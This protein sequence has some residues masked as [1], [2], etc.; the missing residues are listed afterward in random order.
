[1][2]LTVLASSSAG[3]GYLLTNG[4]ETLIIEAGIRLKSVKGALNFS[5]TGIAGCLVSHRHGD[6]SKYIREYAMAGIS[7]LTSRDVMD[8]QDPLIARTMCR[9]LSEGKGYKTGNFKIIPFSVEHDVPCLGFLINHPETGNILF[10]T[11]TYLLEYTFPGLNHILIEANYFDDR[12]EDN[13]VSGRVHPSQR[14]RL[15]QTHMELET[16]KDILRANDLSKVVSI[17]LLHL[18]SDNS[19]EERF[20]REVREITGKQV[21]A[22]K[23]GLTIDMNINPY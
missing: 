23:R 1:M 9:E 3:N 6:H 17:V 22:A 15:L 21:F 18:S 8:R 16:C 20:V 19:D 11:D 10:A 4:R 7:I 14:P 5:L 13:I 12:L 2:N